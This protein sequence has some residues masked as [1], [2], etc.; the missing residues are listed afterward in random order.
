MNISKYLAILG[1]LFLTETVSAQNNNAEN[2]LPKVSIIFSDAHFTRSAEEKETGN[3][4]CQNG[5]LISDYC[6]STVIRNYYLL[7]FSMIVHKINDKNIYPL[8][9]RFTSSSG[10]K[11][12]IHILDDISDL[13]PEQIYDYKIETPFSEYGWYNFEIG[14]NLIIDAKKQNSV[15][16]AYDKTSLYVERPPGKIIKKRRS[17]KRR[18]KEKRGYKNGLR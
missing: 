2:D 5:R 3:I 7:S 15:F 14:E 17:I 13:E 18:G 9:I 12:T 8:D 11:E 10:A 4:S 16:T 1:L 6:I